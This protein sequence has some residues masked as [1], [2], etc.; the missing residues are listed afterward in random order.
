MI[1]LGFGAKQ[2][3]LTLGMGSILVE[4]DVLPAAGG[5]SRNLR[6]A[7]SQFEPIQTG[8]IRIRITYVGETTETSWALKWSSAIVTAR[9]LKKIIK[10]LSVVARV[11]LKKEIV[12]KGRVY[13]NSGS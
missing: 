4:I 6:R 1:T 12:V 3:L 5:S 10:Q 8:Q 9:W 13:D 7:N 11:L 2:N